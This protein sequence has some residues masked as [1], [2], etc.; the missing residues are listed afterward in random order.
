MSCSKFVLEDRFNAVS[1]NVQGNII[2]LA[3]LHLEKF[4][5][6]TTV[7]V[8]KVTDRNRFSGELTWRY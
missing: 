8:S 2:R 1:I 5:D 7:T 3:V 4:L 6:N